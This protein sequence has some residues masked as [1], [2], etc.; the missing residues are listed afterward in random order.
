M[1]MGGKD[2]AQKQTQFWQASTWQTLLNLSEL[3][4]ISRIWTLKSHVRA[5]KSMAPRR[6]T[7][8]TLT[9]WFSRTNTQCIAEQRGGNLN[10]Y[11][12]QLICFSFTTS[13]QLKKKI[14]KKVVRKNLSSNQYLNYYILKFHRASFNQYLRYLWAFV[15]HSM[16]KNAEWHKIY[17]GRRPRIRVRVQ[18][19]TPNE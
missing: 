6:T 18:T 17:E 4:K 19:Q 10:R 16:Y 2:K 3:A 14:N 1:F 13:I 7:S 15:L 11:L 8:S 5:F 12:T 9:R